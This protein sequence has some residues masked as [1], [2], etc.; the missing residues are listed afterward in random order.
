[1]ARLPRAPSIFFA[2]AAFVVAL[3]PL[4][5]RRLKTVG[6]MGTDA[7]NTTLP[8]A[9][10]GLKG[11]AHEEDGPRLRGPAQDP[12]G[13]NTTPPDADPSLQGG[14]EHQ[15]EERK[16]SGTGQKPAGEDDGE[17][18][19]YEDEHSLKLEAEERLKEEE[20]ISQNEVAN[21]ESVKKVATEE[22]ITTQIGV[23]NQ[24]RVK[25]AAS[26]SEFATNEQK[27]SSPEK[28]KEE[29][30]RCCCTVEGQ[31][32]WYNKDAL[33]KS[34]KLTYKTK[35]GNLLPSIL[36][37]KTCP[38]LYTTDKHD[39]TVDP[40]A[41]IGGKCKKTSHGQDKCGNETAVFQGTKC[42]PEVVAEHIAK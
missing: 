21:Q 10:L 35:P 18:A 7:E 13:Q 29:G 2:V 22:N 4:S 16:L 23:A 5:S 6:E 39:C 32:S 42:S 41:D 3:R 37:K 24:E 8:D 34:H 40:G 15:E 28:K 14:H 36:W 12:V 17:Y 1:M 9:D 27:D 30:A 11:L 20:L 38:L 31:C 25:E 33:Y 26:D 19:E